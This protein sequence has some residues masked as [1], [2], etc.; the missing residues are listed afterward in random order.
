MGLF[1]ARPSCILFY[2]T[3]F[4]TPVFSI[5]F[6]GFLSGVVMIFWD[7]GRVFTIAVSN[8]NYELKKVTIIQSSIIWLNA[9]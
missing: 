1:R 8:G 5:L 3:P 6:R 2:S 9:L 7:R 4:L